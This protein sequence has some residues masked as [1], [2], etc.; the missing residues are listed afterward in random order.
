MTS[1]PGIFQQRLLNYNACRKPPGALDVNP[2][3]NYVS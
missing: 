2:L 3:R 1:L